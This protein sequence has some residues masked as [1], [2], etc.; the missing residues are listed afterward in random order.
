[1]NFLSKY[2]IDFG[3][4]VIF[5]A[6]IFLAFKKVILSPN[7]FLFGKEGDGLKNYFTPAYYLKYDQGLHF[8]GMNYPYG[9]HISFTDNQPTLSLF[10]KY[11]NNN[12]FD[13][14]NHGIAMVNITM[15]LSLLGCAFFL[16]KLLRE[17]DVPSW[18]AITGGLLITFLSPQLAR[19]HAHFALGH[20]VFI[21]MNIWLCFQVM[22]GRR[23]WIMAGLLSIC[24]F[25]QSFVHFYFLP[26]TLAFGLSFGFIYYLFKRKEAGSRKQLIAL[27]LGLFIAAIATLGTSIA[28]DPITDRQ[29]TPYGLYT[30]TSS[31]ESVFFPSTGPLKDVVKTKNQKWE[32]LGY[33]GFLGLPFLIFFIIHFIRR[34]KQ[35]TFLFTTEIKQHQ[36]LY[37]SL[38]SAIVVFLFSTGILYRMGLSLALEVFP[39]LKQFRSLGRFIWIFY[40]LFLIF[41]FVQL[42]YFFRQKV[43]LKKT[44]LPKAL[45]ISA[46]L[47]LGLEAYWSYNANTLKIFNQNKYFQ[48]DTTPFTDQLDKA[49]H[50]VDD[51]QA[52]LALPL[53]L[54]G[55]NKV[56]VTTG[57]WPAREAISVSYE[58]GLPLM[59]VMMSR[60]S[61]SQALDLLEFVSPVNYKRRMEA[62][63]ERPILVI[64]QEKALNAI[65]R[66][67]VA[68][69]ELLFEYKDRNIYACTMDDALHQPAITDSL[70]AQTAALLRSKQVITN[71]W[72]EEGAPAFA[73]SAGKAID[74]GEIWSGQVVDTMIYEVSFWINIY[75]SPAAR[76]HIQ[77]EKWTEEGQRVYKGHFKYEVTH[78][79][80]GDWMR[81]HWEFNGL[82]TDTFKVLI[83]SKDR[84]IDELLI[85]PIDTPVVTRS[86]E[87]LL[88][89]NYLVK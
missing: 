89:N 45:V 52:I 77:F 81:V 88:F 71:H 78:A 3:A 43:F 25:L 53:F 66:Q 14:S 41:I 8:S 20:A 10:L 34:R 26:I 85:R 9:E 70:I 46:L 67:F 68:K 48:T 29:E 2:K 63:D 27:L 33:V 42:S 62:M 57:V 5:A 11:I 49:R 17:F 28:T 54:V 40:Y 22:K 15:I 65:E 32:G 73:G 86:A 64:S 87:D 30:Y 61:E 4:L 58:T 79:V 38:I 84:I 59:D 44:W 21:P 72:N 80:Q 60:T 55:P 47:L 24:L 18:L 39:P 76:P 75:D 12:F 13:V 23:P 56:Q 1:M 6:A 7:A 50:H 83:D 31:F 36:L 37:A 35:Q 82:P 74:K 16:Y 51:Y 19:F 69:S